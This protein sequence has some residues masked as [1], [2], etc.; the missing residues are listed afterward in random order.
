MIILESP[1]HKRFE[2]H[3]SQYANLVYNLS[4]VLACSVKTG[5]LLARDTMLEARLN[6]TPGLGVSPRLWFYQTVVDLWLAPN[7]HQML[8]PK[9][10]RRREKRWESLFPRPVDS[11]LIFLSDEQEVLLYFLRKLESFQR[12]AV[13]LRLMEDLPVESIARVMSLGERRVITTIKESVAL[14]GENLA[15]VGVPTPERPDEQEAA[16]TSVLKGWK[17]L[18]APMALKVNVIELRVSVRWLLQKRLANT[19]SLRLMVLILLV[20]LAL[21]A[22]MLGYMWYTGHHLKA[23]VIQ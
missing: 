19:Y 10:F 6:F 22:A 7:R 15:S 3:W 16:V 23:W 18:Q 2:D 8:L 20:A 13:I 17:P 1:E 12:V 9:F 4:I 11:G 5:W 14:L 21:L